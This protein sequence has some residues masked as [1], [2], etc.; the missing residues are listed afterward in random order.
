MMFATSFKVLFHTFIKVFL[1]LLSQVADL[2][3]IDDRHVRNVFRISIVEGSTFKESPQLVEDLS[4]P[5]GCEDLKPDG[6]AVI[7]T[8]TPDS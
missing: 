4:F 5:P 7:S 1:K 2:A 8:G 6:L 3:A